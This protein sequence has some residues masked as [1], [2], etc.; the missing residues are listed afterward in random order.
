MK[1][2]ILTYAPFEQ[3]VLRTPLYPFQ[4]FE[5]LTA[6]E[7]DFDHRL[8]QCFSEDLIKEAVFLASP[9]FYFELEKWY[10]GNLEDK[11]V[12]KV[13]LSFLKYLSRMSSR[14]T[15]F[16]LFAGCTLG[17]FAENT[18]LKLRDTSEHQRHTRPDMNY[19]VALS[20]DLAKK[21]HIKKQLTYFPNSSLYTIGPQLRYIEYFYV[22]GRR[23]HHIVEV[24]NSEYLQRVLAESA[25]GTSLKDLTQVLVDD[26]VSLEEAQGFLDELLESQVLTSSLE[27]SVSGPPFV[28]QILNILRSLQNCEKEI[29][30]LEGLSKGF[31]NLDKGLEH[32]ISNYISLSNRLKEEPTSFELKFLFQTD[33]ELNTE[34]CTLSKENL[35]QIRTAMVLFNKITKPFT[36]KNLEEFREAFSRR[37]EE[38]EMPLS[39]V[40]DVET[41]IGYL[42]NSGNGDTNPLIDDLVLPMQVDPH[43]TSEKKFKKFHMVLMQKFEEALKKG[44]IVV[45]LKNSD[46]PD[47]PLNWDDLPDTLSSMVELVAEDGQDK[48]KISGFGGSSAANLLGRFCHEESSITAFTKEIVAKEKAMNPEKVLA[49]IVHLPEARVGN[50][51]MRPSFRDFEIPYLAKSSLPADQQLPLEDLFISVRRNR[52]ILRSKRLGKEVVPRLTNSHNFSV[53]ALPIYQFLCDMQSLNQRSSIGFNLGPISSLLDFWPRV[54]YDNL[55]LHQATWR[56][57]KVDIQRLIPLKERIDALKAAAQTFKQY[58]GLPQYVMLSDGDNELLIDFENAFS[59]QMLLETV[60]NRDEFLLTEFLHHQKS[61]VTSKKGHFANQVIVSFYNQAKVNNVSKTKNNSYATA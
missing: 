15:P 36:E 12:K 22:A 13:K 51:L 48:I 11:R 38:R 58:R 5:Q 42:Q 10:N 4:Y 56:I 20:Q 8:R 14:C 1:K 17:E 37:Y 54:E 50:I 7:N 40:L 46:I 25:K 16:G 3:F 59:I 41:G 9:T 44:E 6:T 24:D 53:N 45:R 55:I 18:N 30:F 23:K 32:K 28:N 49:E 52:I 33:L 57:K 21:E 27:P 31:L 35:S 43:E 39:H 34:I 47:L 2:N 26:E 61:R 29:S 60:K 19:L